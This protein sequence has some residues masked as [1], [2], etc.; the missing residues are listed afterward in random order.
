[1]RLRH[2]LEWMG[3]RKKPVRCAVACTVREGWV[4]TVGFFS[5]ATAKAAAGATYSEHGQAHMGP[6]HSPAKRRVA[7]CVPLGWCCRPRCCLT[8]S[9]GEQVYKVRPACVDEARWLHPSRPREVVSPSPSHN[10]TG[11]SEQMA[12]AVL[13]VLPCMS[14]AI[15]LRMGCRCLVMTSRIGATPSHAAVPSSTCGQLRC[16]RS[17]IGDREC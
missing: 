17:V 6:H 3:L 14:R 1:M 4:I 13:V 8:C 9:C 2:D 15:C 12:R 16:R 10:T 11:V 5:S 7:P